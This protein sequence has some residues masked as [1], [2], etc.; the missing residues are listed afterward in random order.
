MSYSIFLLRFVDGEV[1]ALDAG[2]F[3]R[4]AEPYTVAGSPEEGFSR[5][6]A[7]DGGEA[8]A[9]H[10]AR[11]ASGLEGVTLTH[12]SRGA[13]SACRPGWRPPS[14]P[15]SFPRTVPR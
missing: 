6:R 7:E 10:A 8:G 15:R 13:M 12:V 11:D 9:Y 1:V 4:V 14:E 2:L 3:R 5:L